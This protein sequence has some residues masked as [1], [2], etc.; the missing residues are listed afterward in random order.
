VGERR[1]AS[2]DEGPYVDSLGYRDFLFRQDVLGEGLF[3]DP[4]SMV[5]DARETA[6]DSAFARLETN[7]QRYRALFAASPQISKR[8]LVSRYDLAVTF[9]RGVFDPQPFM[10]ALL[11]TMGMDE[12]VTLDYDIDSTGTDALALTV[13][14]GAGTRDSTGALRLSE[15]DLRLYINDHTASLLP[16]GNEP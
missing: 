5:H 15:G 12:I 8:R 2:A 10:N 16:Q 11:H 13:Y 1:G 4:D 3:R 7:Y 6:R 14:W 9:R